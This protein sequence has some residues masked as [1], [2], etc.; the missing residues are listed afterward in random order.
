MVVFPN[1]KINLGLHILG[2][3]PDGYHDLETVFYP[4]G[5]QDALEAILAK[6]TT[7]TEKNISFS[8]TGLP[9]A[10]DDSQNLCVRAWRL[11]KK[12]FPDLPGMHLH[13]HKAIPMGS[14]LGGGSADGAFALQL[15]SRLAN[16]PISREKLAAYALQLGSDCPFFLLNQ[17]A[18]AS[19][20]GEILEPIAID[21]SAYRILLIHPGI[22][23]STALAFSGIRPRKPVCTL[24]DLPDLAIS[25]WKQAVQNDF[26]EAIGRHFPPIT[27]LINDLYQAGA[28]YAN[29]SGSGS[30]VFGIFSELPASLPVFPRE[31][32][33]YSI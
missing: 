12:D 7:Q 13:L 9:I 3:R 8:Q 11:L 6:P 22:H 5:L 19:G 30:C 31:Y 4:V 15:I 29:M 17:P 21:L 1:C 32:R 24:R 16:L 18:Y 23:I 28:L 25:E 14:G 27:A 2:K 33:V 20:R 26:T 10:G